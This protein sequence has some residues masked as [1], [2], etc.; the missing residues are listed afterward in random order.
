M[1]ANLDEAQEILITIGEENE[2]TIQ[3]RKRINWKKTLDKHIRPIPTIKNEEEIENVIFNLQTALN[4]N[5]T[6][7]KEKFKQTIRNRPQE[8]QEG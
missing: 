6:T 3:T 1:L 2:E 4:R 8:G 5:T 7:T